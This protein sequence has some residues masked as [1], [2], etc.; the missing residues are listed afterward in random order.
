[1]GA[2]A[3]KIG[4]GDIRKRLRNGLVGKWYVFDTRNDKRVPMRRRSDDGKGSHALRASGMFPHYMLLLHLPTRTTVSLR[5]PPYP[6]HVQSR[7]TERRKIRYS[8]YLELIILLILPREKPS[9]QGNCIGYPST[10]G[11]QCDANDYTILDSFSCVLIPQEL[12][13]IDWRSTIVFRHKTGLTGSESPLGRWLPRHS[14][15][16]SWTLS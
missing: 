6:R 11:P 5:C 12:Q 16:S 4:D 1:M 15:S 9:G 2:G 7:I 3:G 8:E 14:G 13:S 10:V